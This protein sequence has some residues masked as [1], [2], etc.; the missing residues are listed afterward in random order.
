MLDLQPTNMHKLSQAKT[1]FIY[2][3]S[4]AVVP[5]P[6]DWRD[7]ISI[8]GLWRFHINSL[9]ACV[10]I[11]SPSG[12][13]FLDSDEDWTPPE[14]LYVYLTTLPDLPLMLSA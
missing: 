13:W 3:F 6:N 14:G 8:S 10:L 12:Y 5:K 1:P 2:N 9:S 4:A 7:F 11:T